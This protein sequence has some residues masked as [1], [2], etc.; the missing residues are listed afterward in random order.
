[1]SK[2]HL[3]TIDAITLM[4]KDLAD[5]QFVVE[6]LLPQGLQILSGKAKAGKS[7]LLLSLCLCV[8]SGNEFWNRKTKQ[9]TVLYLCLEDSENRLQARLE[10]LTTSPPPQLYFATIVKSLS[11]GLTKQIESFIIDHPDTVLVV[12]D[13]LQKIRVGSNDANPYA[14][15]Y[16]DIGLLKEL[17]D[18]YGIA[19]IVVQHL[20]KQFDS[21]PH[22]MVSGSTGLLGASDG[23]YVLQ[24][25][26]DGTAKL[27]IR[28][29]DIEE[30][31][32]TIHFD[33]DDLVWQYISSDTPVQEQMNRDPVMPLLVSY[34]QRE[35]QF[36]GTAQELSEVMK[37][38]YN[39]EIKGN[40]LSRKL[41]QYKNQ[42]AEKGIAYERTRSGARREIT[43]SFSDNDD[44]DGND[45]ILG[46]GKTSSHP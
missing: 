40:V 13:T 2:H 12:I 30:Q 5:I 34:L 16:N 37:A 38:N 17:A 45:D 1:M 36:S 15:D 27:Y 18:K 28:G 14:S 43:L 42:L 24:K 46:S 8:A 7:W 25:E 35:K 6:G 22:S 21:D 4:N 41:Q 23:S 11:D 29:R 44:H 39:T 10:E 3:E 31:V 33:G 9:G 19:M 20:R 32:L 26:M